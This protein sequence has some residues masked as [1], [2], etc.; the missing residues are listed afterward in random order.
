MRWDCKVYTVIF[1]QF[2]TRYPWLLLINEIISCRVYTCTSIHT[3]IYRKY[4]TVS[5]YIPVYTH[6][7]TRSIICMLQCFKKKYVN[8]IHVYD[9]AWHYFHHRDYCAY[10]LHIFYFYSYIF[11]VCICTNVTSF[12]HFICPFSL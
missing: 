4:F 2:S 12:P 1:L 10:S 5:F 11:N 6:D 7:G 8:V 3:Y 9:S